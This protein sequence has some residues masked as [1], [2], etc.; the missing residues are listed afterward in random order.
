MA[1]RGESKTRCSARVSSTAPRFD[2]RCPP[3]HRHRLDQ[4]VADLVPRARATPRRRACAAPRGRRSL[5][6]RGPPWGQSLLSADRTW[7]AGELPFC[8][9]RPS[10]DP[11]AMTDA[12]ARVRVR[13]PAPSLAPGPSAARGRG[14]RSSPPPPRGGP[15]TDAFR[16]TTTAIGSGSPLFTS[17]T[18]LRSSVLRPATSAVIQPMRRSP[19]AAAIAANGSSHETYCGDSTVAPTSRALTAATGATPSTT[20]TGAD[21]RRCTNHQTP[22]TPT[23]AERGEPE[24]RPV[25][26]HPDAGRTLLH[27]GV[28]MREHVHHRPDGALDL[29]PRGATEGE[30]LDRPLGPGPR[31][32]RDR[33]GHR[34]REERTERSPAPTRRERGSQGEWPDLG[35]AGD[36]DQ[37]AARDHR[38]PARERE[39]PDGER[40]REEVEAQVQERVPEER[41]TEQQVHQRGTSAP[42]PGEQ[43]ARPPRR[44]RPGSTS[45][46]PLRPGR[47]DRRAPRSPPG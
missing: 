31:D 29:P 11:N 40:D 16:S 25:G 33:P 28:S 15:T 41:E 20:C 24:A 37:R 8:R 36:P 47:C 19:P 14:A 1:S 34:D 26:H 18:R 39:S 44:A 7:V 6:A 9:D 45:R 38:P 5:R 30:H 46:A 13:G 22:A 3:L 12:P 27:P 21:G 43:R 4:H 42:A 10:D 23:S 17:F 2:P 32:P 35:E